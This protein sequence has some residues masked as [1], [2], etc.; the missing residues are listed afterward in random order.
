MNLASLPLPF[1]VRRPNRSRVIFSATVS[2]VRRPRLSAIK[3]PDAVLFLLQRF[4][5]R[6]QSFIVVGSHC[7]SAILLQ[8]V[9]INGG[10]RNRERPS[11]MA[12]FSTVIFADQ[13]Q[14]LCR[15]CSIWF[16]IN[17]LVLMHKEDNK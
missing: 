12:I 13:T 14:L 17:L 6:V 7:Y 2:G 4:F 5:C 15:S 10:L 11:K 1:L 3:N 16:I 8:L 9:L